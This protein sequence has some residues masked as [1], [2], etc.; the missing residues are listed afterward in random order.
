MVSQPSGSISPVQSFHD[1]REYFR[2]LSD[3]AR[4]SILDQLAATQDDLNVTDLARAVRMSQPLCSWHLRRLVKFGFVRMRRVGREVRCSIDR[5]R[6][7]EYERLFSE[8]L[9]ER[10]ARAR[11]RAGIGHK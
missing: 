9:D 4:L 2:T 3:G 8:L 1:L 5:T 11:N 10:N 6:L 7:Q